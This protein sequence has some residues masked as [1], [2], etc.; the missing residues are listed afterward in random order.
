MKTLSWLAGLL[1][2][3]APA[4]AHWDFLLGVQN[5]RATVILPQPHPLQTMSLLFGQY[6]RE[7]G[8]EYYIDPNTGFGHLSAASIRTVWISP[9]LTGRIGST[10]VACASGCAN[11]FAMNDEGHEHIRFRATQPGV[12]IWDLRVV[13]ARD[14][15]GNPVADMEGVYR[16]YFRAGNPHYLY[17]A[18]QAPNY[19]GDLYNLNLTL[20]L[21]QGNQVV[22]TTSLPPAPNALHAYMASFAQAGNY[23]VVAKL[24]KHLSRRVNLNLQGATLANWQ[25]PVAGDVNND[26][27]IDDADLLQI[28]FAF[29]SSD[30]DADVNG[31]GV[32]DDA[33]LLMVLFNFGASGEGRP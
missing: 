30:S 16:I 3:T 8:I 7:L 22:Q 19:Q 27:V 5:G 20:Q 28:L 9:G 33:D 23:T 17:G 2:I 18:V 11:Y 32:V 21:R 14:L 26:D 1:L 31:D 15:N 6:T 24:D 13:D 4:R 25:F 12:Y 10:D 29:G